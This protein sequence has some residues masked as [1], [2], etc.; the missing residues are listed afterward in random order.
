MTQLLSSI[1]GRSG[2]VVRGGLDGRLI[3]RHR[4]STRPSCEG[5]E[6]RQLLSNYY[7]INAASGKVLESPASR[8]NG[9]I[10]QQNQLDGALGNAASAVKSWP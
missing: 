4:R 10:V 1:L 2:K 9:A 5:L 6:V 3:R 8:Q 7:M